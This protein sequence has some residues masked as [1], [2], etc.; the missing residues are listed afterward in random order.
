MHDMVR[1]IRRFFT[2]IFDIFTIFRDIL[3][4]NVFQS[5]M[6]QMSLHPPDIKYSQIVIDSDKRKKLV[7]KS[8]IIPPKRLIEML[9]QKVSF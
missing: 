1:R 8:Y 7:K 2:I 9:L 3:N 4:S 5:T 6:Q